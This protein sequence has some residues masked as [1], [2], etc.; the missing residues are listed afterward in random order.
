MKSPFSNAACHTRRAVFLD[1]S[2]H[3]TSQPCCMHA[4]NAPP[5]SS[6]M[7]ILQAMQMP[8]S[9]DAC[10]ADGAAWVRRSAQE[11]R[12][13]R[14]GL[15]VRTP[16]AQAEAANTIVVVYARGMRCPERLPLCESEAGWCVHTTCVEAAGRGLSRLPR[17][18][19]A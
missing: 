9:C 19:P 18:R 12:S 7:R 17:P 4:C 14:L 15:T 16:G 3:A 1:A 10:H 11:P 5:A 6:L 8:D 2:M 13:S